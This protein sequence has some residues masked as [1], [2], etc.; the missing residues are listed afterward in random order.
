MNAHRRIRIEWTTNHAAVGYAPTRDA[1]I[2]ARKNLINNARRAPAIG[3]RQA[4]AAIAEAS[5]LAGSILHA[6][7]AVWADTGEELTADDW[8]EIE[9]HRD[10][11]NHARQCRA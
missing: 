6:T 4:L 5:R 9:Y 2:D 1:A 11:I 8:N 3:W 7:A 10:C